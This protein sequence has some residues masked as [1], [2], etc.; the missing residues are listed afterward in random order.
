MLDSVGGFPVHDTVG[1]V[2]EQQLSI[3]RRL[4]LCRRDPGDSDA[5]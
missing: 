5:D 4:G 1:V 2:V 3:G